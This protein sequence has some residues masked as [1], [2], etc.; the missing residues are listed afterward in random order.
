MYTKA[1]RHICRLR[2][3]S[4]AQLMIA[5]DGHE[6]VVKFKDEC[7]AAHSFCNVANSVMCSWPSETSM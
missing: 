7:V 6:Y 3:G 4:Q 5:D 1:I 2:G